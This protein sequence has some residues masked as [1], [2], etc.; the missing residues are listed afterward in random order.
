MSAVQMRVR[1]AVHAV[2]KWLAHGSPPGEAV[3]RQ[4]IVLRFLHAAGF[5]IWNPAEVVPEETNSSGTRSDFLIRVG[6]GKFALELKGM[7]VAL[8]AR[9][10]Q[11]VVTYAAS[12]GTP[13]AVLTNGRVWVILDRT[14]QPGGTFQ[15]HEVLKLELGQ[16]GDTFADDFAA[17]FDPAVW[18]SDGFSAAVQQVGAQQQRRLDEARIRREKTAAVD[19]VQ[20]QYQIPSFEL[21]AQAA[22]EM[23]RLTEVERDVLLGRPLPTAQSLIETFAQ[24]SG[25]VPESISFSFWIKTAAAR[26]DYSLTKGTWVIKAG[27]T[28]VKEVKPYAGGVQRERA[29][30][31]AAGVLVDQAD[32]LLFAAD[33]EYTNPS[34][35][36]GIVSGGAK[37]GWDVWRDDQGRPAQMYRPTSAR[38]D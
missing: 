7:T 25:T 26:A 5:D 19:A 6:A 13:W 31:L 27:S 11:Q 10:Y 1:E 34:R 36:A 29:Q 30:L 9:D 2:Q 16:E 21:A 38:A 37:N 24:S 23:N 8:S 12:E 17:L 14:H 22:V 33:V 18:R 28:A 35:A 3:V 15:D 32:Q 20:A 4:A